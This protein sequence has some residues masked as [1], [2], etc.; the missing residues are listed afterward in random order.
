MSLTDAG[1]KAL[2]P[3]P[4]RY[5]VSDGHG[6]SLDVLPSGK[7][8]WVYKYRQNGQQ[9]KVNVGR[10]PDLSLKDARAVRSEL[11][12]K[13]AKGKS[14]AKEK[15]LARAGLNLEPTV[16]EFAE[17]YYSEYIEKRYKDPRDGRRYIDKEI[18]PALGTKKVREVTSVDVQRMVY[19]KRDHGQPAAGVA[20]RGILKRMFDYAV[21]WHLVEVNPATQVATRF[22]GVSRQRTR[23]LSVNEIR[24]YLRTLYRSNIRR[25]FKLALNLLLLTMVRKGELR[26]AEWREVDL[27]A[28]EW[29]IPGSRTK[30]G[31]PHIVYLSTQAIELFRELK[32]LAGDSTF[33]MPGRGSN[34]KPFA[35]NG[36]NQAL[37]GIT[38]DIDAFT[39]HDMRRTASTLLNGNGWSSDPIELALGHHIGGIR[40]IYNVADYAAERKK[41]LQWWGDYV[42]SIMTEGNVIEGNF[43]RA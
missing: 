8:S 6:L 5:M 18:I 29:H 24:V 34:K 26:L 13:V 21:E 36:L 15:K 1:I 19:R 10:Y 38:F 9:E 41:M 43:K 27:D 22:I 20:L 39:I 14:P 12:T 3:K 35:A 32:E 28:G 17:R 33:V 23:A 4:K 11:A 31:A 2:K 7:M 16:A 25:Q 40:G 42:S 37:D 30:T